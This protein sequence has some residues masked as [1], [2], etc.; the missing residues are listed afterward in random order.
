MILPEGPPH[1]EALFAP[2]H[3]PKAP[4]CL[5]LSLAPCPIRPLF[6]APAHTVRVL[7]SAP[8]PAVCGRHAQG[9]VLHSMTPDCASPA[10]GTPHRHT[11]ILKSPTVR[12]FPPAAVLVLTLV[13]ALLLPV[14][15]TLADSVTCDF[16]D[17]VD[18]P[19]EWKVSMPP[20]FNNTDRR[21]LG[22]YYN[23][24]KNSSVMIQIGESEYGQD[25][26]DLVA[27]I[28]ASLKETGCTILSGP[29]PDGPLMRI[30]ATMTGT[31]AVMWVGSNADLMALT[32]V[33]GDTETCR[34]FL[35]R[36][37]NADPLLLP[38]AEQA[39][40]LEIPAPDGAPAKAPET[41]GS[42]TGSEPK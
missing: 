33:S 40:R 1:A 8:R 28:V 3:L 39:A 35:M 38:T 31:P 6:P 11:M 25:L 23:K 32:V 9:R 4:A 17:V 2:G 26:P 29:E 18:M 12:S 41:S 22:H 30:L 16:Y 20:G 14:R 13:C 19:E 34:D 21:S 24:A 5:Y 37:R 7:H 36:M 10:T 27:H 15:E 42:G